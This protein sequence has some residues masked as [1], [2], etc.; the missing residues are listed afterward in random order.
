MKPSSLLV[1]FSFFL[2]WYDL[3]YRLTWVQSYFWSW[4]WPV[5]YRNFCSGL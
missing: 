2:P 1:W 3:K 4:Q 5:V